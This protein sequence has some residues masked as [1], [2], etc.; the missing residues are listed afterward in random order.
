MA[1]EPKEANAITKSTDVTLLSLKQQQQ[2]M[3]RECATGWSKLPHQ[4]QM[5]QWSQM[6][7][8]SLSTTHPMLL[9]SARQLLCH[10]FFLSSPKDIFSLLLQDDMGGEGRERNINWS[11]P[12]RAQVEDCMCPDTQERTHNIAMCP[13]WGLNLQPFGHEMTL[14]PT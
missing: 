12:V 13:D 2:V 10:P 4:C 8:L 14:Q 1:S 5:D 11:P 7:P 6:P 9:Q 3:S